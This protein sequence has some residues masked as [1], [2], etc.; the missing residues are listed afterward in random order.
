M[1]CECSQLGP[2]TIIE[3]YN[4]ILIALPHFP[5]AIIP[6]IA[7][8]VLWSFFGA[9]WFILQLWGNFKDR[10]E[11]AATDAKKE[12]ELMKRRRL[13]RGARGS[14]NERRSSTIGG[15]AGPPVGPGE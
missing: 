8:I 3:D 7:M 13:Q 1:K 9:M 2:I 4:Y 11:E 6:I 14:I 5:D 12:M 10:Q 15:R